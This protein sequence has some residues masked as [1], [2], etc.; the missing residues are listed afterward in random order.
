VLNGA[1]G[2]TVVLIGCIRQMPGHQKQRD[3]LWPRRRIRQARQ[4]KVDDV[5][6]QIVLAACDENFRTRD[7][8]RTVLDG[9]SA[10]LEQAQ[11]CTGMGFRQAH[12]ASPLTGVK[13]R[14]IE[15][16][17]FIGRVTRQSK[18]GAGT[19]NGVQREG[20]VCSHKHFFHQYGKHLGHSLAAEL[21]IT[22]Q[23][24][25]SPVGECLVGLLETC[26]REH[27]PTFEAAALFITTAIDWRENFAG[28]LC[29]TLQ[30]SVHEV[31]RN[32]C[33]GRH[34]HAQGGGALHFVQNEMHVFEGCLIACHVVLRRTLETARTDL[35]Q[36]RN[37][38]QSAC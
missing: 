4:D 3:P 22:A 18:A 37:C 1:A 7:Q 12:G 19:E 28:Q 32:L 17:Q 8:V 10:G 31:G 27:S 14:Q 11:I 25:P 5:A 24:N 26:R 29:G 35:G 30:Y 34:G 21:W 16:F 20:G 6:A 23:P 36:R 13:T 15:R 38:G 33:R 9:H 2:H